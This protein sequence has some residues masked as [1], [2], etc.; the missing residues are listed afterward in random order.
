MKNYFSE[1]LNSINK[2]MAIKAVHFDNQAG[3]PKIERGF[4]GK[5]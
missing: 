4:G 2:Q 5:I 3:S 1:F